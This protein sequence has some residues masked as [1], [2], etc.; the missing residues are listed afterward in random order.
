MQNKRGHV[1][2]V[3]L[4]AILLGVVSAPALVHIAQAA[5]SAKTA[6][7]GSLTIDIPETSFVVIDQFTYQYDR[8]CAEGFFSCNSVAKTWIGTETSFN[9]TCSGTPTSSV[10]T[11]AN[12]PLQQLVTDSKCGFFDGTAL[13]D[14]TTQNSTGTRVSFSNSS[15]PNTK[16]SSRRTDIECTYVSPPPVD[17]RVGYVNP[18]D[19]PTCWDLTSTTGALPTITPLGTAAAESALCNSQNPLKYSFTLADTSSSNGT[20]VSGLTVTLTDNATNPVQTWSEAL[21]NLTVALS[22]TGVDFTY[23]GSAGA[24]GTVGLLTSTDGST[25][26]VGCTSEPAKVNAIQATPGGVPACGPVPTGCATT[27]QFAG[28]N[29]VGGDQASYTALTASPGLDPAGSPYSLTVAATLKSSV[30]GQASLGIDVCAQV[31]VD[32]G[33]CSPTTPTCPQ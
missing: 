8:T 19:V 9:S 7:S 25:Y 28:N 21:T 26:N 24:N 16:E 17:P 31:T 29:G 30:A 20:R 33:Q 27:D 1:I 22:A 18:G 15:P 13:A 10:S 23:T 6:Q 4:F 14:P 5:S 32:A 3:G 12:G 11:A 2:L